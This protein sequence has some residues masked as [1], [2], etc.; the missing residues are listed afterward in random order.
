[1]GD[2]GAV[3]FNGDGKPDLLGGSGSGTTQVTIV[4][5]NGD[6]TFQTP[7]PVFTVSGVNADA[8]ADL[9]G[10]GE[11]DIMFGYDNGTIGVRLNTTPSAPR[12]TSGDATTFVT[13]AASPFTITATGFPAAV[14]T[15]SG[16]LPAGITFVD[17]GNGTAK[18]RGTPSATAGGIYVLTIKA[19]NGVTPNAKQTF[20]LIV[21]QAPAIT[22]ANTTTFTIGSLGKFTI[23]TSG[24][25]ISAITE[26]GT[27][28][29]GVKFVDNG[30]GTAKLRG[31]PEASTA[32]SYPITIKAKNGVTPN[33]KETFDLVVMSPVVGNSV[34]PAIGRTDTPADGAPAVCAI[35][36]SGAGDDT[37]VG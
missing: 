26:N 35:L 19:K 32:G 4:P 15:E 7:V 22:S 37:L 27:L 31:T 30:D 16:A 29:T 28:P 5:G 9:T 21:D 36:L 3:D 23:T 18:L 13:G 2:G 17:K 11:A 10:D 14:L 12:I 20:T 1:V 24:F 6:G 33:S 25:P 8:E 34:S